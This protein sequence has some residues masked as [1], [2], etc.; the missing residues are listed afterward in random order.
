MLCLIR[1]NSVGFGVICLDFRCSVP[2][3]TLVFVCVFVLVREVY[4][5]RMGKKRFSPT[6]EAAAACRIL[7]WRLKGT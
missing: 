3:L 2:R 1:E 7:T 4:W 6:V 5:S